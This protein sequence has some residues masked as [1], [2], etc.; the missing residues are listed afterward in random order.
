MATISPVIITNGYE[1]HGHCR[2][3]RRG[4]EASSVPLVEL[5]AKGPF[6]FC[7]WIDT[8]GDSTEGGPFRRRTHRVM[9]VLHAPPVP[10]GIAT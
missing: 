1:S 3:C 7:R 6:G 8:V 10:I 4:E 5:K 9:F 2:G